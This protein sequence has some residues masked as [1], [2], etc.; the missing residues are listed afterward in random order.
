M[1]LTK[2][3]NTCLTDLLMSSEPLYREELLREREMVEGVDTTGDVKAP[4]CFNSGVTGAYM[5]PPPLPPLPGPVGAPLTPAEFV[6]GF[7][8]GRLGNKSACGRFMAHSSKSPSEVVALPSG[9]CTLHLSFPFFRGM[10]LHKKAEII[11]GAR[12]VSRTPKK[13]EDL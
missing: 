11:L 10:V 4:G 8:A 2:L 3:L 9:A 1:L 6:G 7:G 13:R 12:F 5:A